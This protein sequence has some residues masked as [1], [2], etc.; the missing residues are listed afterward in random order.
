MNSRDERKRPYRSPG[1]EAAASRTREAILQSA[2]RLFEEQGWS[3][4]TVRS[5]GD[6]AGVSQKT[7]EAVFRTKAAI[8]QASV[9]YAI[10]GDLD[11]RPIP[12]REAVARMEATTSAAA[13]LDLHARHVRAVNE[14]SARL[15][16]AVEQAATADPAVKKLWLQMNR[17][18]AYGV[19]WA[20][21]TL[22][23]K[24]GRRRGLRRSDVESTFWVALDW[25]TYR[26]LTE[27]AHLAPGGFERWLRN[28]YRSTLEE[29]E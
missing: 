7:V 10:R 16:W 9:D 28:Y 26:V 19:R 27:R 5:I 25:G 17:N 4:T 6:A 12:Q 3:A 18:R 21:T 8:L 11:R 2:T 15:A 1:R 24:P 29:P 20:I 13:M 22:L 23:A 14:R